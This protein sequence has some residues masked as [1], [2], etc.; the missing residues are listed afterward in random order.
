MYGDTDE[1]Y[2]W[3]ESQGNAKRFREWRKRNQFKKIVIF[4]IGVGAEGL[5]RHAVQ[6]EEEFSNATYI[7]INL[8][9]DELGNRDNILYFLTCA[10]DAFR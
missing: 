2:I 6:Y 5:K 10:K 4:E 8:E 9:I 3:D 7:S 1:T